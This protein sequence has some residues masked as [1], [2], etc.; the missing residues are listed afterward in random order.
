MTPSVRIDADLMIPG[1]GDP[2]RDA[3]VVLDGDVIAYAGPRAA[4]PESPAAVA[5]VPVV[6]PGLW[7]CHA[8]FLGARNADF[9]MLVREP[10]ALQVARAVRQAADALAAGITSV[11]EVG[12]YGVYL[13]RAIDEDVV[14][15][16]TIYAAGAMLSQTGGHGDLHDL[17]L[18]TIADLSAHDGPLQLC[19]GVAECQR[20]VR[21]Q[22][23]KNARLIKVHAS[24]GVLSDLDHP[25]HQQFSDEELTAI[26]QE[27]ARAERIVAAHC[28]GKPGIMAAIEAG[29]RTIEHGTY[30]DEE[31][32]A[33]M[34]ETGTILV[35]TRSIVAR[36]LGALDQ[37]QASS[38]RKG[39]EIAERHLEAMHLAR[40]AGV[41]IAAGTDFA[42]VGEASLVPFGRNGEEI[43]H[44]VGVGYSPLEAIEAATAAAPATLG[45]QAP[46]SGQLLAGYEA[47]VIALDADPLTDVSVLVGPEHVT[48]VWR[49][50]RLA[51]SPAGQ[52]R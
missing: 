19:D 3:T 30:L 32:A 8:H 11:R 21:L 16:P 17:P 41:P 9:S 36:L 44:L 51:K 27:A 34:V 40:E 35:A 7:D 1:R 45:P 2:V 29:V 15:G 23:R 25:V 50:G 46:R 42:T 26:V 20:A 10:Q 18:A 31:A 12:G 37:L 24:G 33:A 6:M 47:D 4:A 48:H 13:A 14:P 49:R 38:A 5:R 52:D 22:L 43:G 28:H 39:R